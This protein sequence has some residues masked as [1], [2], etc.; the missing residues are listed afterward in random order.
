MRFIDRAIGTILKDD[1]AP[2]LEALETFGTYMATSR[3][4]RKAFEE[5]SAATSGMFGWSQPHRRLTVRVPISYAVSTVA[6]RLHEFQALHP[7]ID[8]A[9]H[10]F[11][12]D[13]ILNPGKIFD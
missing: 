2:L 3:P 8:Y 1:K 4:D 7:G 12:P 9:A 10:A 11:D 6:P 5:L 13:G